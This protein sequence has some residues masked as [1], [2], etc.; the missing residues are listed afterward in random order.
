[1]TPHWIFREP[2]FALGLPVYLLAA[3]VFPL[4]LGWTGATWPAFAA[5]A[6]IAAGLLSAANLLVRPVDHPGWTHALQQALLGLPALALPA[7]LAFAIGTLAGPV[8]EAF[9]E[10]MCASHG[11]AESDNAAVESDDTF[12]VTPDCVA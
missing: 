1:V 10:E 12:D 11:A 3:L 7:A 8:D 9:D 6:V 4:H 2:A 5:Y